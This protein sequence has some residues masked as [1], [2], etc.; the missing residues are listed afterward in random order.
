[1]GLST[2]PPDP[3]VVLSV[4]DKT[5]IQAL[6]R[7][8]VPRPPVPGQRATRTH[9]DQRNGTTTLLAALD[10]AVGTVVGTMTDRHRTEDVGAVLDPVA[11]GLAPETEVHGILATLSAPTSAPLPRRPVAM[12]GLRP[13]PRDRTT[14]GRPRHAHLGLLDAC[15]GGRRLATGPATTEDRH[16][17]FP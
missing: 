17:Q 11:A 6:G 1:M 3:A 10:V 14:G 16:R 4:D 9:D 15:G 13:T 2:N 7:T 12:R 5:R 8:R